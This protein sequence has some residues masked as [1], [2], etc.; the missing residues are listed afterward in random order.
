M[1]YA[2]SI[3][4]PDGVRFVGPLAPLAGELKGEFARLGYATSSATAQLQL[5]AHL[6]RWLQTEELGTKDLTGPVIERFLAARRRDYSNHYSLQALTPLLAYL[7]RVESAPEPVAPEPCSGTGRLLARFGDYLSVERGL[8][9]PVV[10]AY[11]R[12]VSPFVEEAVGAGQ[13]PDLGGLTAADVRRFLVANLPGLSR[14]SAQMTACALRSFLRFCYVEGIVEMSLVGAIP[15]VAHRRLAG[16]PQDLTA[17]QVASLLD[18]CD[19]R[20]PAGRRDYA[21][22]VCLHRLGLRCGETARLTLDDIDWETGTLSIHGKGGHTDRMPLPVDVGQAVADYLRHGR[23]DTSARAVFVRAHAPLTAM[24]PSSLSCIVARAAR[25]AGLGTVHAHRLR[26]TAA[27]R[28]LNAGAS[29]EEVAQLLRHAGTATTL[30]Y[31]K[32]DQRRLAGLARP[33]PT[34]G[35]VW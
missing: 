21:V 35:G 2:H 15:A 11:T 1:V 5:A 19:R 10:Q 32:T 31:A 12:W 26:H 28:V 7:R 17:S 4:N 34:V 30:I 33:W 8:S 22:M 18:G 25:R 24:A 16:F 23:P 13:E 29:L 9:A 20:T 27:T 14:K 3:H 6:S